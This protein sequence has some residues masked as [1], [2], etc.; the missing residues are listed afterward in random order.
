MALDCMA[1]RSRAIYLVEGQ[2][3]S[4]KITLETKYGKVTIEV[5]NEDLSLPSLIDLVIKPMLRAAGF[6]EKTIEETFSE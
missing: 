2:A 1:V 4:T 3:M 5:P 6:A